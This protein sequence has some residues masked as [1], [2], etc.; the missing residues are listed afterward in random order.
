[1]KCAQKKIGIL[2]GGGVGDL[3]VLRPFVE[4]AKAATGAT[5]YLLSAA[6]RAPQLLEELRLDVQTVF[7]SKRP[8]EILEALRVWRGRFELLY[9]GPCPRLTTRLLGSLLQPRRLWSKRHPGCSAYI[10]E[11]IRADIAELGWRQP[12]KAELPWQ[13][14]PGAAADAAAYL[15]LHPAAGAGWETTRWPPERWR[16]AIERVLEQTGLGVK[17]VGVGGEAVFLRSLADGLPADRVQLCVDQPLAE[18]AGLIAGSR[19]VVCHNSGIL[20]LAAL[21]Q[22]KTVCVTGSTSVWWRPGYPWVA[23]VTSG[24]CSLACNRRRCPVPGFRARC[25][26]QLDTDAVWQQ[27]FDHFGLGDQ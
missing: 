5:P 12:A 1:M 25:I 14:T 17:L 8:S 15:V 6:L 22:Q 19:G 2:W 7:L 10:A 16:A 27:M 21:L 20:H 11:Q 13:I 23:N 9:L 3:L 4:A 24:A 26:M 18:T